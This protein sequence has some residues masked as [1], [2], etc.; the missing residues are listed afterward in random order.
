MLKH[1]QTLLPHI[2]KAGEVV[3]T[4]YSTPFHVTW[5]GQNDPLTEADMSVHRILKEAIRDH[6]PGDYFLSEEELAEDVRLQN[7][8]VWILDPIDGTREF[9]N[10]N[11]EFAISLGLSVQGEAILGIVYN[12][13]TG[14]LVWGAKELGVQYI[15]NTPYSDPQKEN[16]QK[17]VLHKIDSPQLLVSK[18]E[19]ERGHFTNPYWTNHFQIRPIGSIA[20]KLA[21]IAAG[22]ADLVVS[23]KPKSEWD[24]CAGVAL[25]NASG[26]K[27]LTL[28][29]FEEFKFNEINLT[30]DGIIS[31]NPVLIQKMME[32]DKEFLQGSYKPRR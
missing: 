14:E 8:R 15:H 27:C 2:L 1:L 32:S 23:V 26:G 3:S 13:I 31:G 11:P 12:P 16:F 21:L 25:V 6:W 18:T 9:V 29:Q 5:K 17:M 19:M 4:I 22:K 24:I 28:K 30:K 10:K 20:Y 7:E